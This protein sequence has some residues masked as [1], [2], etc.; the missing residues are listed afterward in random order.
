MKIF[1]SIGKKVNP[2]E[3]VKE[4]S[5]I[6]MG[7]F[8]MAVGLVVFIA[9][10]KLAP[11]GVYGIAIILHHLFEFPIGITGIALDIPLL[12]MGTL[13]L[14]PKF[15]FKTVIGIVSLSGF[16]TLLEFLYGYEPLIKL[17]V[18]N[19]II[20]DPAANLIIALF[21]GVLVG[22]GLGLV[23]KARATSGGTDIVAMV[24]K[25]YFK[26]IPLGTMIM[27][28]DSVIV[29]AALAIFKDW[30]IP[31]YSWFVIYV[32]GF[33]IDK[34]ISG[35]AKR[36]AVL[37]ISDQHDEIKEFI[38]KELDRGGTFIHGEGMYN[39][40]EKKII[41]TTMSSKELPSLLYHIHETDPKAFVSIL[42]ATDVFGEG[43]NSLREKALH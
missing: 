35:F 34:V 1:K 40:A 30:T 7:T 37:I 33:T 9:P 6:L 24:L 32:C 38:I 36:K 8:L 26:H 11:G 14:G 27:M 19:K 41:F 3:L 29:L 42:D 4:Y 17:I 10:L 25:K 31:L 21:G 5:S 12:I 28:V 39:K 22:L 18:D 23:F 20:P 13:I 2:K 16:I 43:F 15:G